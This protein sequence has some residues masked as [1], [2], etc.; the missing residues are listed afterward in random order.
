MTGA[1]LRRPRRAAPTGPRRSARE[2]RRYECDARC[3]CSGKSSDA[4]MV[5]VKIA[6][7]TLSETSGGMWTNAVK[8][9]FKRRT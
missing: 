5:T 8:S 9:I 4:P 2:G 6:M 3:P 7:M 1:P